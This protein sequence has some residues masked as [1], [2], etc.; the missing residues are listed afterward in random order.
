MKPASLSLR[1]GLGVGLLGSV[2]LILLII[3][4]YFVLE[5]QLDIRARLSLD[6]KMDQIRHRLS[7]DMGP[8][9]LPE[10]SHAL[11]DLIIGHDYLSLALLPAEPGQP[12][13]M[14]TESF[15]DWQALDQ[16]DFNSG[17]PEWTASNGHNLLTT[18]KIIELKNGE[19]VRAYLTLD[20]HA[21]AALLGAFLRSSLVASPFLLVLIALGARLAA[22]RGLQ[23]LR[24]F[25]KVASL[26]STDD[27]SHRIPVKRLPDELKDAANALNTMLGRLDEGVSQ[28][29]QFSDDLS[30]ELRSPINNILGKTQVAL[31]RPRDAKAYQ[32]VLESNVEELE[33]VARIV[34]EMLFLAQVSHPK[35]LLPTDSVQLR[36]EAEKVIELFEISAEEKDL[37][38]RVTGKGNI[39]GDRLMIQRAISNLISNAIRHAP[40]SSIVSIDIR[41]DE[42]GVAL[43]VENPGPGI[44][45][46]HLVHLFERFYRVDQ[47]RARSAGGTGLGL[48]I[49]KTIMDLH[50]GTATVH[51]SEIGPTTFQ[52]RF[53]RIAP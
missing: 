45:A 7:E 11:R 22:Q 35:V 21:D 23:P 38:I 14:E 40:K 13:L 10:G 3:F 41:E 53:P 44:S 52:L 24:R 26:V 43:A 25:G 17:S 9:V 19:S 20:R 5:H 51:S 8:G 28:L 18:R 34:S 1:I 47:S 42:S 37:K 6:S 31:S 15:V 39:T 46:E 16:L 50:E 29:T 33:R 27:M 30:H 32:S 48:A 2:L 36:L 49:V 12:P 4:T